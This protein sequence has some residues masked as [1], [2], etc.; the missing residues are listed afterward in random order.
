[1]R[2]NLL[3][4]FRDRGYFNARVNT[5][6]GEE[7]GEKTVTYQVSRGPRR[8]IEEIEFRGNSHF[9][10]HQLKQHVAASEAGLLDRGRYDETS[11]KLLAAFYQS[12]GFNQVEVTSQLTPLGGRALILRFDVDEGPRDVV[13]GLQ[14]KGNTIPVAK[15]AP[16][17]LQLR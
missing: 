14:V 7:N 11:I 13:A 17:G 8:K 1:G 5:T 16:G 10:A 2:K 3:N 9:S 12:Q 15:L 4:H 6:L